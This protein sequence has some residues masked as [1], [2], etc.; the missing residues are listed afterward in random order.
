MCGPLFMK[1]LNLAAWVFCFIPIQFA[2]SN[3]PQGITPVGAQVA[4]NSDNSIPP[5]SGGLV[6]SLEELNAN[7]GYRDPFPEDRVLF[8]IDRQNIN[9]Y[10]EKLSGG[11]AALVESNKDFRIP[12]YRSKRS[13]TFPDEQLKQQRTKGPKGCAINWEHCVV[14]YPTPL[15]GI[16]VMMNHLRRYRGGSIERSFDTVS[17]KNGRVLRIGARDTKVFRSSM[18]D[19]PKDSAFAYLLEFL[20]PPE[21]VGTIY[22]VHEPSDI[23]GK[24]LAWVYNSGQRRVRRAPDLAYDNAQDGTDGLAVVD[25]YDGFNG[26]MDRYDWILHGKRELLIPY[27]NYKIGDKNVDL[28]SVLGKRSLNPDY[29]R[30]ELHRVWMIEARLKPGYQHIYHKRIFYIDEDA[31]AVAL[32]ESYDSKGDL[33][34]VG[35]H[36]IMQLYDVNLPWYRF[37]YWQDLNDNSYVVTGL[38]NRYRGRGRFGQRFRGADFTADALRRKGH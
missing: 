18:D 5:W 16:E 11:L 26:A 36:S 15:N 25:Q 7:E 24:R 37:E 21:F 28:S 27:N 19:P 20:S 32:S 4:G 6:S 29:L 31:W 9:Q 3:E 14:P 17:V 22:L 30:F 33:W 12:V 10:R 38:D 35:M 2:Y 13:V 8:Y 34:R 23:D 1:I